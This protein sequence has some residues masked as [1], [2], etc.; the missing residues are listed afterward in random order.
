MLDVG[1]DA[2]LVI[3]RNRTFHDSPRRALG[4][5]HTPAQVFPDDVP[6]AKGLHRRP[7]LPSNRFLPPVPSR[8]SWVREEWQCGEREGV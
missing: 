5:C 2:D 8:P 6:D 4:M 3:T 1:P 7:G